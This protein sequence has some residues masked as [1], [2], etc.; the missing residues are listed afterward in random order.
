[1]KTNISTLA[2][3]F[4]ATIVASHAQTAATPAAGSVTVP[5]ASQPAPVTL[6]TATGAAVPI[7]SVTMF[8][9]QFD[10]GLKQGF[11]QI[12]G[13]GYL[14]GTLIFVKTTGPDK[15]TEAWIWTSGAAALS[16][17]EIADLRSGLR[18]RAQVAATTK[19]ALSELAVG[20][21]SPR[22]FVRSLKSG[23]ITTPATPAT[24]VGSAAAAK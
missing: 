14:K 10:A 1:M 3:A 8:S 11:S 4:I 20:V 2:F 18:A 19:Q 21:M 22:I 24:P 7:T 15:R 13:E 12:G 6:I 16:T 17:D 23:L 5:T 9:S